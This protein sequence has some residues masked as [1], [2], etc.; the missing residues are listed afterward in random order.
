MGEND[1]NYHLDECYEVAD[2]EKSNKLNVYEDEVPIGLV[3]VDSMNKQTV[4]RPYVGLFDSG[5]SHTFWNIKSL[6]KGCVPRKLEGVTSATLAG[7]LESTLE[8]DLQ[9]VAFPEFYKTRRLT[10]LK[11]RVFTAPCQYDVIIGRDVLREMGL[12]IDFKDNKISW[13][14]CHV[15]MRSFRR[16]FCHGEMEPS[17]AE[18]LFLNHIEADLED[19]HAHPTCA[20]SDD[21]DSTC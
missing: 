11:A 6:P 16:D 17:I 15:P 9:D 4:R 14:D 3:I 10:E 12:K 21:E 20:T 8:I 7:T 19:D 13:D 1:E 18:Q 5:S 2:D